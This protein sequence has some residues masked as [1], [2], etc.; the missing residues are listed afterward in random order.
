MNII[1][2]PESRLETLLRLAATEPAHRPE[3]CKVLLESNVLVLG[4]AE[5]DQPGEKNLQAGS[6]ISLVN[7]QD[8]SGN[9]IIPFFSSMDALEASVETDEPYLEMPVSVLFEMTLGEKLIMNPHSEYGKEFYPDEVESLLSTGLI[10]ESLQHMIEEDT[11][12]MLGQP[13][14]YPAQLV[15]SLTTLFSKHANVTAGYLGLIHD[16]SHDEEPNLIIGILGEGDLELVI[17][18]AGLVARDTTDDDDVIDF[19]VV[20]ESD[21]GISSYFLTETKPFYE[22][23]WGSKMKPYTEPGEA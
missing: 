16:A 15:D 1:E 20:E 4:S 14:T 22:H 18:E 7:W 13:E 3:F 6:S 23:R 12:V 10:Q 9:E 8:E 21:D 17:N 5:Q 2:E 11:E 19:I